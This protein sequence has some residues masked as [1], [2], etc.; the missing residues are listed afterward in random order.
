MDG[1]DGRRRG[2]GLWRISSPAQDVAL[3]AESQRNSFTSTR[4]LKAATNFPLQKNTVI[5]KLK[6]ADLR[7]RAAV[8]SVLTDGNNY[9]AQHLLRAV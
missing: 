8:K 7:I 2:T 6:E 3:V 1:Q 4:E 5:S 9:T